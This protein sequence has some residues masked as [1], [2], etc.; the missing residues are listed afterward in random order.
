[1]RVYRS[2]SKEPPTAPAARPPM[3]LQISEA[4]LANVSIPASPDSSEDCG[5]TIRMASGSCC[6]ENALMGHVVFWRRLYQSAQVGCK[7]L[8]LIAFGN[9]FCCAGSECQVTDRPPSL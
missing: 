4:Y 2:V 9:G 3:K 5:Y 8:E 6:R 1:M 7:S